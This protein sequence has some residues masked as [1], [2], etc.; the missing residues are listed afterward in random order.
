MS[1]IKPKVIVETKISFTSSILKAVK[2]V[3]GTIIGLLAA[4]VV[5]QLGILIVLLISALT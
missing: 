4:M 1:W 5:L 3:V 2:I